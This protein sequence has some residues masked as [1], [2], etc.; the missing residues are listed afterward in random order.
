MDPAHSQKQCHRSC[1]VQPVWWATA[2]DHPTACRMGL[3]GT[4]ALESH[5]DTS[6]ALP[7]FAYCSRIQSHINVKTQMHLF[8]SLSH[9]DLELHHLWFLNKGKQETSCS[10]VNHLEA[11][12]HNLLILGVEAISS[13]WWQRIIKTDLMIILGDQ[14]FLTHE[15]KA[16][17]P[18]WLLVCCM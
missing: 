8:D 2:K 6:A 1:P 9:K 5:W 14:L 18:S 17:H 10:P 7:P 16:S 3:P 15:D 4:G 13:F 12:F 11:S